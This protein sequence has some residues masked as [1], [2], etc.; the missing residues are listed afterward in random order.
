MKVLVAYMS[1]TGNTKKVAEAIHAGI[2]CEK[3]IKPIAEVQDIGAYDL[4]FLGFPTHGAGPDKKVKKYLATHC[5][6]GRNVA[7][8]VTHAAP[9]DSPEVPGS[10]A[11]FK[12]AAAGANVVGCF[13]CRGEL[14]KGVKAIMRI[15]PNKQ[16]RTWAKIDDSM[17]QPDAARLEKARAFAK[18]TVARIKP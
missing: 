9:E 11:K 8:F 12:E 13:D 7:L 15:S 3:E 2:A 17:G 10:L 5:T 18:E 16:L 1:S 4:S 14:S 6:T